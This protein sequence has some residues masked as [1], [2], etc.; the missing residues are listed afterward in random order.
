MLSGRRTVG[1]MAAMGWTGDPAEALERLH[2][3]TPPAKEL[4]E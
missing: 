2:L 4:G 3:F 1:E